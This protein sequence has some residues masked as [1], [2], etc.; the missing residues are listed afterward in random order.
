MKN[1]PEAGDAVT[2][3]A[4]VVN[5]GDEATPAADYR[6]LIDG[7]TVATGTLVD[8]QPNEQRVVSLPW[9]WQ[10]GAHTVG[11]EID[12]NDLIAEATENNNAVVDR[13]DAISIGYWV[14]QSVYDYFHEHQREI[15]EDANSWE[16][17]AQRHIERWNEFSEDAIYELSPL[18]VLDRFRIDK[19]TVVPDGALPLSGGIPSNHPDLSDKTVDLMWGFPATLLSG[20]FY[21][22]TTNATNTN[23]FFY[24]GSLIHELGHA[25]YLIDNYSFDVSNTAAF[26]SVLVTE[27][28]QPLAG[29]DLM[30]FLAFNE[31]LYY[32]REGG[33]M[34]GPY[35]DGWSPYEAAALNLIAGERASQGNANAPGNIGVFVNDLP[36]S[37]RVQFIT[38]SGELAAG[39]NVKIFRSE[40]APG[41]YNK[42]F[43]DTVDMEFTTDSSGEILLPRN[44]FYADQS[45]TFAW[46]EPPELLLRVEYDGKLWYEFFE[47]AAFNLE[48]WRGN[49]AE[50]QYVIELPGPGDTRVAAD[51]GLE[52]HDKPITRGAT[53]VSAANGTDFGPQ[54]VGTPSHQAMFVIN[55]FGSQQLS[56]T[57]S[58]RVVVSGPAASDF[59]V[60]EQPDEH[61]GAG[62]LTTF[63][64]S[65]TPSTTG[66]R[67]ATLSIASND[68]D[69]GTFSFA[70]SGQGYLPGDYNLS[71]TVGLADY[72]VWRDSLGATVTPYSAADGD[73]SGVIDAGDHAVWANEYGQTAPAALE[74]V[75]SDAD[76]LAASL[77]IDPQ[78]PS[79]GSHASAARAQASESAESA[80]DAALLLLLREQAGAQAVAELSAHSEGTSAQVGEQ[81]ALKLALEGL[82]KALNV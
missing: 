45:E 44:P 71:N 63:R 60:T 74:A 70:I 55:N 77:M 36:Q 41:F 19:V 43:N 25:R 21:A 34:T 1:N 59:L 46:P 75:E 9:T 32:N 57:G 65:F 29:S 33:I 66:V 6:W 12:P 24:E 30:P 11:F 72:T 58:P 23:P 27:G 47:I 61:I 50:G 69:E 52:A 28:G 17:W 48:Y 31:V 81:A 54:Y 26:T 22:D 37:N 53:T 62:T 5:W 3:E 40:P 79:R 8:L 78:L 15:D 20:S 76:N 39:A 16:D 7:A 82:D 10:T 68:S 13:T 56:L 4:H 51:I 49:T 73:G 64:V 42:V 18:G 80:V 35:R 2:F 67:S 38:E 14:E